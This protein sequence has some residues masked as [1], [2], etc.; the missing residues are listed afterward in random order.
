MTSDVA[1]CSCVPRYQTIVHVLALVWLIAP[2]VAR[3]QN[4][5]IILKNQFTS[6]FIESPHVD[7]HK[8]QD[9]T[10]NVEQLKR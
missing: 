5:T 6:N 3:C 4:G 7:T 10:I 1:I 2:A 9:T 8:P